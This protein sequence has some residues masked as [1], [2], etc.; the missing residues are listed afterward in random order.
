MRRAAIVAA[1]L[2]VACTFRLREDMFFHPG[3]PA[4]A[5]DTTKWSLP[6]GATATDVM[7]SMADGTRLHA[8]RIV[9]EGATAEVLYFGGDSFRTEL[10]G[11]MT[12][13]GLLAHPVN[14]LMID[15]RGYGRSEG[16]PT[17]D[18]MQTDVLA[19]YDWLRTQSQLPI[20]IHGF[21][22]GS[23]MAAYVAE[24]RQPA[25]L[26]LESPAT[27]VSDWAKAQ[28][29]IVVRLVI[30]PRMLKEDNLARVK[31]YRGPLLIIAGEAD[32]VTPAAMSRTLL[33]ASPSQ[34][35]EL[36]VVPKAIHG[37][38]FLWPA[39]AAAYQR[40]IAALPQ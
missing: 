1:L 26:V 38:A 12:A 4:A 34:Y 11:A 15:Y 37:N 28:T 33:A 30:P 6:A 7:L 27:N 31:A 13:K 32:K 23:F 18:N 22:L 36:V 24:Q 35:K 14:V 5:D 39:A 25:A 29:P 9:R 16:K 2:L 19:V 20:I 17:I 21:S 3:P 10:F 8:V 40:L